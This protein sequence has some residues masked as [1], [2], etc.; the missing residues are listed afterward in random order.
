MTR[1]DWVAIN[2]ICL[3]R[4]RGGT[5]VEAE[6]LPAN[7]TSGRTTVPAIVPNSGK[8]NSE[9]GDPILEQTEHIARGLRR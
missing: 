1:V 3:T 6:T 7:L 8:R 4:H 2:C 9:E 5:P